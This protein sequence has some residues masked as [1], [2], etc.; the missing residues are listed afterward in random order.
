MSSWSSVSNHLPSDSLLYTKDKP[1]NLFKPL[2][3]SIQ[4]LMSEKNLTDAPSYFNI[5]FMET[6]TELNYWHL[7]IYIY[8]YLLEEY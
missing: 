6:Q 8:A 7:T 1:P 2:L 3:L 4:L 5:F